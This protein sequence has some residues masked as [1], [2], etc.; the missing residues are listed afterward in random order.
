[1]HPVFVT[2]LPILAVAFVATLFIKE[3]PLRNTAFADEDAGKEMLRS[4]NQSVPEGVHGLDQATN[5]T[6]K[7]KLLLTGLSLEYLAY[8]IENAD[9][10]FPDLVAA[11][12]ALAPDEPPDV[13]GPPPE[14]ARLYAREVV[15][16]LA[17]QMMLAA[18]RVEGELASR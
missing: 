13:T 17:V 12:S 11:A 16:P 4:A 8:R 7:R 10:E 14:R 5:G 9:G 2:A 18:R 15:R 6:V 1:M 3:L